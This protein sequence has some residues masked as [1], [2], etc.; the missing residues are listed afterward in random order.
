MTVVEERLQGQERRIP[1]RAIAYWRDRV[2]ALKG[3]ATIAALDLEALHTED[4]SHRFILA[5]GP[6]IE[7]TA[8]LLHGADFGRLLEMLPRKTPSRALTRKVPKRFSDVFLRGCRDAVAGDAPVRLEG[9][10]ER[11]DGRRE[12]YRAAF[13]PLTADDGALVRLAFGAFSSCIE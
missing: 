8:L 5:I 9:A 12:L 4:W 2:T 13:I 1:E 10:V 3:N 11:E 7:D 6:D